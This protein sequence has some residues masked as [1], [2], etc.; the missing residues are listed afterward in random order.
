MI[1]KTFCPLPWFSVE[2]SPNGSYKPCCVYTESVPKVH[3]TN[4]TIEEAMYS[5]YMSNLRDRFRKGE[6]PEQCRHCWAEEDSGKTSKRQYSIIKFQKNLENFKGDELEVSPVFL[7]LKLGNVCNIKCRICGSWS[8]SAWAPEEFKL[9][10]NNKAFEMVRAG[11]WPNDSRNFWLGLDAVL[12][13]VEYFEFTGGEPFLIKHH[14]RILSQS[15]AMGYSK[16]QFIHYN[17]NGTI[18]PGHAIDMIWPH[19]KQVEVAFSI[20]DLGERFEY[21]RHPA[22]WLTV[23]DNIKRFHEV[24]TV[25][26]WLTTQVCITVSMF[27]ILNLPNILDWAKLQKFDMIHINYLHGPDDFCVYQLPDNFKRAV[28]LSYAGRSDLEQ[29]LTPVLNFMNSTQASWSNQERLKKLKYHDDFRGEN[30]AE[31]FPTEWE[32]LN[33]NT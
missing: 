21:Q 15:V 32:L 33:E 9:F 17:T 14:F 26:D 18:Y 2:T 24:R 7:D 25:S 6:R 12:P 28:E 8:S 10:K 11:Q 1:S 29:Y 23:N 5:E 16:N 27:N 22:D 31:T 3:T 19:F 13:F 20:D 4:N 30:F